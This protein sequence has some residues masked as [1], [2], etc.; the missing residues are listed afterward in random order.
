[1][2][3]EP[4]NTT[5]DQQEKPA[6]MP[7]GVTGKGFVKGDPR[8]NRNGRPRSFDQLR[9]LAQNIAHE[10][11]ADGS[12]ITAA[13]AILRQMA[14]DNPERFIEIAFGKVPDQSENYNINLDD[15]SDE[16]LEKLANGGSVRS[17]LAT[18]RGG[19]VKT[20]AAPAASADA[21]AEDITSLSARSD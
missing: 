4:S 17:V 21:T 20:K 13:E 14:H 1:M 2:T 7:G 11:I 15:L 19:K 8:I 5:P 18:A 3:D 16:Q 6:K 12:T 10:R 9:K